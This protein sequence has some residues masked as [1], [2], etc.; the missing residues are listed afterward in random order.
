MIMAGFMIG[1]R[2]ALVVG[3]VTANGTGVLVEQGTVGTVVGYTRYQ[4]QIDFGDGQP[5]I[6]PCHFLELL[7]WPD[8]IPMPDDG[9]SLYTWNL[10]ADLV[11]RANGGA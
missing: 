4:P 8:G 10:Y 11:R 2:V 5:K 3:A 6:V 1:D 7:D 9:D